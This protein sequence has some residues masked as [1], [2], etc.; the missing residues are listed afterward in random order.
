M[1]QP[2]ERL[3]GS[4]HEGDPVAVYELRVD[5]FLPFIESD[6]KSNISGH[7]V[8]DFL[9]LSD[10]VRNQYQYGEVKSFLN[11]GHVI[12]LRTSIY[13]VSVTHFL[14]LRQRA[15]RTFH[16]EVVHGFYP[17]GTAKS[18]EYEQVAHT[19]LLGQ[20][21]D[22]VSSKTTS[23]TIVFGQVII[24]NCVRN[25]TVTD[26]LDFRSEVT[27]W[28]PDKYSYS[29]DIPPLSGPNAPEC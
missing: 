2:I 16:L 19:L 10:T 20:H 22:V 15:G 29:I 8:S 4:F 26:T 27:V 7:S 18:V 14:D 24:V 3:V 11:L 9:A 21:I 5:H 28:Q 13:N 25:R 1:S 17:Y 6:I 23:N 12:G